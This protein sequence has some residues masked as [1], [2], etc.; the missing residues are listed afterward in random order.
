LLDSTLHDDVLSLT[1]VAHGP[2]PED[3]ALRLGE[4]A[5]PTRVDL[6]FD[7]A[8]SP[9]HLAAGDVVRSRHGVGEKERALARRDA[10]RIGLLRSS[11]APVEP[12]DPTS[13]P[14]IVR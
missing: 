13:I 10:L 12:D 7:G 6:L 9:A 1:F 3:L 8:L 5:Y 2:C 11:G 4:G 14:V